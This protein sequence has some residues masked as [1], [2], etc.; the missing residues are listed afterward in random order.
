MTRWH[1]ET[2]REELVVVPQCEITFVHHIGLRH[3]YAWPQ[4]WP[5]RSVLYGV[6]GPQE[7]EWYSALLR[8]LAERTGIDTEALLARAGDWLPFGHAT[9]V[10]YWGSA[11]PIH[12]LDFFVRPQ[13]CCSATRLAS[14]LLRQ[15]EVS[16]V[17]YAHK[18]SKCKLAVLRELGFGPRLPRTWDPRLPFAP[19]DLVVMRRAARLRSQALGDRRNIRAGVDC[20]RSLRERSR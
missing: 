4:G 3:L 11:R 10:P 9:L 2:A 13:A 6:Y 17:A 8:I 14:R 19:G 15:T 1:W 18:E 12:L 20:S 16:V 7:G 5:I